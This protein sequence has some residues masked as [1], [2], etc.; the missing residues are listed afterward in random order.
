MIMINPIELIPGSFLGLAVASNK[1]LGT[2]IGV[3]NLLINIPVM[4]LCVKIFG[5]KMLCYTVIIIVATSFLTDLLKVV[6]PD[7]MYMPAVA[8]ALVSGTAMGLGA[9]LLL[10]AGGTMAGTTALSRIINRRYP[11]ISVGTLLIIMDSMVI[12]T[13]CALLRSFSALL[14]SLLY[15]ITCSRT[16]DF[17]M[18]AAENRIYKGA[19]G[20]EQRV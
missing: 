6:A 1:I 4:V 5:K 7:R 3:V 8:I 17:V 13:G 14:Y 12:L 15:T 18:A 16:I 2:P 9:G 20:Y 11:R 19:G 10:V